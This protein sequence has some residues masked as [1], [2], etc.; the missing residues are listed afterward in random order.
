MIVEVVVPTLESV[1]GRRMSTP[2]IRPTKNVKV[3][4]TQR[5]SPCS[6]AIL[7]PLS[8]FTSPGRKNE[9]IPKHL[10]DSVFRGIDAIGYEQ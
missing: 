4:Q 9:S 1:Y 7:I 5:D 6:D 8:R 3:N 2:K 10:L